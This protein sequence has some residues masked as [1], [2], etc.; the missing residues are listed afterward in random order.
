MPPPTRYTPQHR[1]PSFRGEEGVRA[2]PVPRWAVVGIFLMILFYFVTEARDFLMPVSLA[3]LLFF[4]FVPFR[5][6]M[7]RFGVNATASAGMVTLGL[8]AL[9]VVLG[10]FIS[11]PVSDIIDNGSSISARLEQRVQELRE[12]VAPLERA[13]ARLDE[14]TTV[15]TPTEAPPEAATGA[16]ADLIA[17]SAATQAAEDQPI[18]VE[19]KNDTPSTLQSLMAAGPSVA[20]QIIFTLFLL[21]FLLAS[22]DL[23]YLKIVQSFDTLSEKRAAYMAL[24]EIEAAIG[25]YLGSITIINAGLGVCVGLAMWFWGMPQPILWGVG[26]FIVNF[27]PYLGSV[28]GIAAAFIVAL[29]TFPDFYT[30]LMVALTY[31]A[32]TSLEGQ[33]ITPYFVSRRLQLNTVVVFVTVAMWAWLWSV[34]GMI[35]AVPILVVMKVL[36][37]HIPGLE[38]FGNF[39]A[40]EAPPALEDED[41]AEAH[42]VVDA[43]EAAS[44]DPAPPPG[45][46]SAALTE[47]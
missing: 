4:V 32:L 7:G 47:R 24:R 46:A 8:V 45:P 13:A 6:M 25:S 39:L 18:K 19:V 3:L 35:V 22:G 14:V 16:A 34:L 1:F 37:D 17:P 5:R 43:G 31:F 11:G 9:V 26:A 33:L 41:E 21:F 15:D 30:H 27:I 10:Y 28:A 23:M 12:S 38:K 40:G 20:S 29:L 2:A 42:V 44:P 36:A